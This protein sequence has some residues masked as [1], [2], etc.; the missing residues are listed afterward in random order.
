MTT[1][2]MKWPPPSVMPEAVRNSVSMRSEMTGA[3]AGIT[4]LS[5]AGVAARQPSPGCACDA[6]VISETVSA[7]ENARRRK[8]R[9]VRTLVKVDD[10]SLQCGGCGLRAITYPELAEQAVD[11]GLHCR[12]RDKKCRGDLLVAVAAHDKAQHLSLAVGERRSVHALGQALGYRCRNARS[13]AVDGANGGEQLLRV[14]PFEKI[15]A[16]TGLQRTVDIFIA[17]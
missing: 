17:I 11:V 3:R 7:A 16:G 2:A 4:S 1:P 10:A 14:H 5:S 6:A 15:A 13:A 8:W 9:R 12:F